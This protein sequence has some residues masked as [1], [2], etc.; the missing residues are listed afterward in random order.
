MTTQRDVA[1]RRLIKPLGRSEKRR[2]NVVR[3]STYHMEGRRLKRKSAFVF[4]H[5]MLLYSNYMQICK[6]YL[7]LTSD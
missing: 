6:L 2:C 1:M 4:G 7:S 3:A 5:N